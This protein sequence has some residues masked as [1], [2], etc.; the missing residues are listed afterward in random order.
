MLLLNVYMLVCLLYIQ[1]NN[2]G[3]FLTCFV[4]LSVGKLVSCQKRMQF[5]GHEVAEFVF[6]AMTCSYFLYFLS[7]CSGYFLVYIVPGVGEKT[8]LLGT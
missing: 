3:C 8:L 4:T 1:A 5:E 7:E 2:Y 6:T